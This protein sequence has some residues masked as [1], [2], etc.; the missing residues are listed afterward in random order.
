MVSFIPLEEIRKLKRTDVVPR[1]TS[2]S[3]QV[4]ESWLGLT[5]SLFKA[6]APELYAHFDQ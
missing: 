4:S 2:L 5:L 6:K 1:L 3:Y